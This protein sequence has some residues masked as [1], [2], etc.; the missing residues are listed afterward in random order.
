MDL[1]LIA[2]AVELLTPTGYVAKVAVEVAAGRVRPAPTGL[3]ESLNE[4]LAARHQVQKVGVLLNQVV[5]KLH[6]TGELPAELVPAVRL[7]ARL[8]LRLEDAAVAV[9]AVRAG[10]AA[11]ARRARGQSE[12]AAQT[13]G[14][15]TREP[16]GGS[17]G[18]SERL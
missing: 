18:E 14:E 8:L 10:R 6:S 11:G 2:A 5:A 17:T 9:G 7:V 15:S 3:V 13:A 4:L 1:L 16:A 12:G